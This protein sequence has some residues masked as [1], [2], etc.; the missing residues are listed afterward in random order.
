[1]H[2]MDERPPRWFTLWWSGIEWL[3]SLPERQRYFVTFISIWLIILVI[4]LFAHFVEPDFL[5]AL[6]G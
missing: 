1:M 5:L 2:W 4:G 3:S 6:L